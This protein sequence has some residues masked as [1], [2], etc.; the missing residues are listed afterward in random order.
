VVWGN[1]GRARIL[2]AGDFGR[3]VVAMLEATDIKF[4]VF[5]IGSGQVTT[6]AEVAALALRAAGHQPAKIVYD[7]ASPTTVARRVLDCS[8]ARDILGW[9]PEVTPAEG[10]RRTVEW[11]RAHK[12][13]WK[14]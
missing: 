14:R 8:K 2:Y 12:D 13:T 10:I 3:A 5:N 9:K 1:P 11:W 4:D 6:V 7:S